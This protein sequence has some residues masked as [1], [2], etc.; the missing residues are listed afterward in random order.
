MGKEGKRG[1]G[2]WSLAA[3]AVAAGLIALVPTLASAHIERASYWPDPGPDT[4]VTPPAGGA[5]PDY[6]PLFTALDKGARGKTRVVCQGKVPR[7][8]A[9]KL[10]RARANLQGRALKRRVTRIKRTYDRKLNRNRSIRRLR[11]AVKGARR[12]G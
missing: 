7:R 5:V 9:A 6:R 1:F 11:G 2:G 12:R 8:P 4:S 10:K 3:V